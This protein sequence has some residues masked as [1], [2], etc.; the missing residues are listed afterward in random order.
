MALVYDLETDTC[1]RQE[2]RKGVNQGKKDGPEQEGRER[3]I[4]SLLQHSAFTVGQIAQAL[5]LTVEQVQQIAQKA[6]TGK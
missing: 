5:G 1:Y 3:V 6:T 4:L 2:L